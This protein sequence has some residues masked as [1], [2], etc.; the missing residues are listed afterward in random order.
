MPELEVCEKE[1]KVCKNVLFLAMAALFDECDLLTDRCS[2]SFILPSVSLTWSYEYAHVGKFLKK[3][4]DFQHL[5]TYSQSMKGR[6]KH[7]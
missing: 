7:F 3:S 5:G 6:R 4:Q 2:H 1:K